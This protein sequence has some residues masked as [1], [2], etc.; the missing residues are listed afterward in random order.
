[1]RY[2]RHIILALVG[3]SLIAC[4]PATNRYDKATGTTLE[5][6]C[7]TRRAFMVGYESLTREPTETETSIYEVYRTFVMGACPPV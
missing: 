7:A 6:R 1:M 2:V 3:I 5:E 4:T